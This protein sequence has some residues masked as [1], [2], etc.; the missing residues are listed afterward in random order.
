[1]RHSMRAMSAESHIAS[2]AADLPSQVRARRVDPVA[3]TSA[4]FARIAGDSRAVAAFRH[5]RHDE[6]L[7]EAAALAKRADLNEL[8][9]AGDPQAVR[10][11]GRTDSS[12]SAGSRAPRQASNTTLRKLDS[13]PAEPLAKIYA[14]AGHI[15]ASMP[16]AAASRNRTVET[17]TPEMRSHP[18]HCITSTRTTS[19]VAGTGP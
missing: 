14:P 13:S 4:T 3:I 5:L 19:T 2:T 8:A 6:A 12:T 15:Y 17:S 18:C 11:G 1:M 16:M 7:A 10:N 9:L